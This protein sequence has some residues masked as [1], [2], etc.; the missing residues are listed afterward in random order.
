[1][2]D[3]PA[4][5]YLG[6]SDALHTHGDSISATPIGP[7]LDHPSYVGM[8]PS[9]QSTDKSPANFDIEGVPWPPGT[10]PVLRG[11]S[12]AIHVF[13]EEGVSPT[14]SPGDCIQSLGVWTQNINHITGVAPFDRMPP[15]HA[16]DDVGPNW[17]LFISGHSDAGI[18]GGY[19]NAWSTFDRYPQTFASGGCPIPPPT[20]PGAYEAY[21]LEGDVD[22]GCG[23]IL[24]YR[25]PEYAASGPQDG[26]EG[27]ETARMDLSSEGF[28]A[29]EFRLTTHFQLEADF[30][31]PPDPGFNP[32]SYGM[33]ATAALTLTLSNGSATA[34]YSFGYLVMKAKGNFGDGTPFTVYTGAVG[35]PVESTANFASVYNPGGHTEFSAH[36]KPTD[37]GVQNLVSDYLIIDRSLSRGTIRVYI[38]G[39]GWFEGPITQDLS[40]YVA[41]KVEIT[42]D[43]ART[44]FVIGQGETQGRTNCLLTP[45]L[46]CPTSTVPVGQEGDPAA[47]PPGVEATGIHFK[48]QIGDPTT[49]LDA[50][51]CML[52][53]AAMALEWHTH[54]AVNVWGGELVPYCGRDPSLIAIE[55]TN[56]DNV[57]QA[58]THWGQTFEI[59][60][61]NP[62]TDVINQLHQA[63]AVVIGGDYG[64]MPTAYKCDVSY[65]GNHA[66]ILL[67]YFSGDNILVGDPICFN[68]KWVPASAIQTYAEAQGIAIWGH[69]SPQKVYFGVSRPWT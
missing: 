55:G 40:G 66:I 31:N 7:T 4:P 5:K 61:G 23:V 30:D 1:M 8:S 67:P 17:K 51:I 9:M 18:S 21:G 43:F 39:C 28:N 48:R 69:T 10:N 49:S 60:A 22:L 34:V 36:A 35:S 12:P 3:G 25:P 33:R 68:F 13:G 38:P 32:W 2:T 41:S 57:R 24:P 19:F 14:P 62:W 45:P 59:R 63:K 37:L 46:F 52:E 47:N 26:E 56:L 64:S 53:S 65:N 44:G 50:H 6:I 11:R 42:H 54:G 15:A 20:A 58:W 27:Y 29:N 16:D